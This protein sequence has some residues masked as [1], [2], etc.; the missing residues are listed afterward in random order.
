MILNIPPFVARMRT[1]LNMI[2]LLFVAVAISA[3]AAAREMHDFSHAAAPVATSDYHYHDDDGGVSTQNAN[4]DLI[5]ESADGALGK[6][7]HS[8]MGS[9]AL[10]VVAQAGEDWP[11]SLIL[12]WQEPGAANTPVLGTLG[13]SPQKRPPRTA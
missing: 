8:H 1:L 3:P 6:F 7:G 12:A 13:W 5:P 4:R 9:T 10:D 2:F 11:G